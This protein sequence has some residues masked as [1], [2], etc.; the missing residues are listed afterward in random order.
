[1]KLKINFG[2]EIFMGNFLF[3]RNLLLFALL[4][5]VNTTVS[6]ILPENLFNPGKWM[7]RERKWEHG[8]NVYQKFFNIK[9]WKD[10]LPE[11]G[12]FAK[13]I[14]PKKKLPSFNVEYLQKYTAESCRSEMCHWMI[15][16]SVVLF[17]SWFNEEVEN[18]MFIL[19]V[20]LNVPY[21]MIQRFNRP[22]IINVMQ[23]NAEKAE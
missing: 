2:S 19:A 15:V 7:F 1:V 12:D 13:K 8:G 16:I 5:I 18:F 23:K 6:L 10:K 4:S 14:F 17:S 3:S 9:K 11:L 22:R 20:V 21:I